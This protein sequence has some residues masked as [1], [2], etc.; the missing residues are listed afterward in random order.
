MKSILCI[1]L[2]VNFLFLEAQNRKVD[3]LKDRPVSEIFNKAKKER[4]YVL[5]DFGSPRCGPCLYIKNQ[6]FTIDSVADFINEH[7]VSAD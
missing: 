3:M 5:L 6:I 1:L 4:K 2:V 7:F